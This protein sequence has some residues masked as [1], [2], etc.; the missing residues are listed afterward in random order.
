M[1][2]VKLPFC[3]LANPLSFVLKGSE[4][5]CGGYLA[6]QPAGKHPAWFGG[7]GCLP[8]HVQLKRRSNINF[9]N[10]P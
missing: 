9:Q 6:V 4:Y 5:L 1:D 7:T 8:E 3:R 10:H 2:P